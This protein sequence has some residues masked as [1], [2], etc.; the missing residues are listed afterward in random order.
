MENPP[1]SEKITPE[2]NIGTGFAELTLSNEIKKACLDAVNKY[3]PKDNLYYVKNLPHIAGNVADNLH[4]T[5]YYGFKKGDN[6]K[7]LSMLKNSNL[8]SLIKLSDVCYRRNTIHNYYIIMLKFEEN[9]GLNGLYE[10]LQNIDSEPKKEHKFHP[11]STLAYIKG[12]LTEE[13]L[14]ELCQKIFQE[15]NFTLIPVETLRYAGY[16]SEI[17]VVKF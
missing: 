1:S 15:L 11:H 17:E 3:V 7:T 2:I 10:V 12:D 5:L 6:V 4:L 14:Q 9:I 8:P 16:D 13:K